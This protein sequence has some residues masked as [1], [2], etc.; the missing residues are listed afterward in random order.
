MDRKKVTRMEKRQ[1]SLPVVTSNCTV[2]PPGRSDERAE[3]RASVND[4]G[5]DE[6][7]L[8]GEASENWSKSN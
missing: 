7:N 2:Y 1:I 4:K 3:G 6:L 8:Y 5:Q